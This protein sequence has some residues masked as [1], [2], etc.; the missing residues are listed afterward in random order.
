MTRSEL[1][2]VI[3][4]LNEDRVLPLLRQRLE[5]VQNRPSNWELLFVSDGST[6]ASSRFIEAW[7]SKDPSVKLIVLTRNFGH[8][9]AVSAGLSFAAGDCVGIMDADL[10][11]EPEI[12]L[13]MYR[14]LRSDNVDIVYAIRTARRE[15]KLKRFF[16]FVFYR[17]YVYLADTPVQADSGDFCV[18]SRR[19][20]R[21]LL[22]L[23][24]KLRFVR[25][26]RAWTGLPSKPFPISRPARA[27]GH[28]QYSLLKLTRLA[29]SGL[30]SFS[31]R[32]LR[33]GFI[34]GTLL[35][36][37][38]VVGALTYLGIALFTDIHLTAPGFSTL[39][40]VLLFS[41][42]LVF[43]YLGVLGEYIGQMF[44]EVKGRPSFIVERTINIET[45]QRSNERD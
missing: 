9:S 37:G 10:Q 6:D 26:L 16:Y 31:T 19:A 40:I 32:P 3:P 39:V 41:N 13:D 4:F 35:C 14:T 28:S 21:V 44:M 5:N 12:L 24:E 29:F 34:C 27:A 22:S 33:L 23:P 11:D 18:M 38:A 42:G 7:A 1:S 30:T 2:I 36:L 43:L 8:Q 17:L 20:V 15:T 25:G 45:T